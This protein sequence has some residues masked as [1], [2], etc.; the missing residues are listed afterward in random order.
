LR[1]IYGIILIRIDKAG[2]IM[3]KNK[4]LYD[5]FKKLDR[6]FFIDGDFKKYAHC[7]SALP[8]GHEQTISQP[9]LVYTMT[10]K[11]DLDKN[12]KV[13]EIGTGSGYQTAFLAE[14]AGEVYTVELIKELSDTARERL[15]KL[16]YENI[17]FRVGDGSQGWEEYAPYDRIIVT[18]A[19]KRI[20]EPLVEQLDLGGKMV[21]PV[22][23]TGI[24]ELLLVEKDKKGE[25]RSQ[26]LGDVMFVELKGQYG[27]G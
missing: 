12:F 26:H 19:A 24:Q 15:A 25:I 13:L 3:D 20:P 6:S 18:A 8:I 17:R 23:G 7:D 22:G 21:I 16:G 14:F 11:L 1:R 4:E 5:F 10:E 9:T 2:G 27:W